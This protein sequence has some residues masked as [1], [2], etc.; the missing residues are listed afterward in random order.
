MKRTLLRK[1][2]ALITEKATKLYILVIN[3]FIQVEEDASNVQAL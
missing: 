1:Y 2:Q 3:E